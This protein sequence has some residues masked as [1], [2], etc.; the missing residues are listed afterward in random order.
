MLF[1][2]QLAENEVVYTWFVSSDNAQAS[3]KSVKISG[4][5]KPK[6][7]LFQSMYLFCLIKNNKY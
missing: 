5:L 2:K 7:H 4:F 1:K 6:V 3:S